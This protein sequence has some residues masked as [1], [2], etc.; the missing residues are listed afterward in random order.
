MSQPMYPP[1][2]P[3]MGYQ[4]QPAPAGFNVGPGVV[5]QQPGV[6]VTATPGMYVL[7]MLQFNTSSIWLDY[8]T[9]S[10]KILIP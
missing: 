1:M 5:Q 10:L 2:D 7:L 9:F 8:S 6:T 4:P 3:N